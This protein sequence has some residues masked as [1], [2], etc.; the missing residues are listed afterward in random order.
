MRLRAR[1][2][3]VPVLALAV[4]T[5][6]ARPGTAAVVDGTY[7]VSDDQVA[8][9]SEDLG[10]LQ[11]TPVTAQDSLRSLVLAEPVLDLAKAEGIGV[12]EQ[13]GIEL[14][15]SIVEQGGGEPWEYS[16]ELV[17]VARMSVA[18][19]Q[20]DDELNAQVNELILNLAVEV[21]PRYGTWDPAIG[22][23]PTEWPWLAF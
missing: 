19:Q 21:N 20:M 8:T 23:T 10:R 4:L 18:G 13:Q 9:F 3:A 11:G 22:I 15:D 17:D 5:G 7:R 12:T 1:F 16:T 6:C 14:L 2:I